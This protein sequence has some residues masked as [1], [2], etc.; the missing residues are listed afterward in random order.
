MR[1][2]NVLQHRAKK[3][4]IGDL[5]AHRDA[6]SIFGVVLA[7]GDGRAQVQWTMHTRTWANLGS[8][9]LRRVNPRRDFRSP[10][11]RL[12]KPSVLGYNEHHE[13]SDSQS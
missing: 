12:H 4:G 2:V 8:L 1:S 13:M 6:L 9:R 11:S 5:V 10:N 3:V 7:L